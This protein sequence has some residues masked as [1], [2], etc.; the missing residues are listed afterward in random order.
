MQSGRASFQTAGAAG[1]E[2]AAHGSLPFASA[3]TFRHSPVRAGY[4]ARV[5]IAGWDQFD[6]E[7][8]SVK[9][10]VAGFQTESIDAP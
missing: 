2:N 6:L 9:P 7:A 4:V 10:P 5:R 8:G 1:A 3:D